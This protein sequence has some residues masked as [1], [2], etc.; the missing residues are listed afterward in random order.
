MAYLIDNLAEALNN[1]ITSARQLIEDCFTAIDAPEGEGSRAFITSYHDRARHHA[2]MI[3]HARKQGWPLPKYAGIPI[4]IKDLFNEAG[5]VTKA[6]SVVLQDVSP[7]DQDATVVA[8]LKA[9]GFIVIGRTNMTEFAF[10]GLGMNVHY[11]SPRSPFERDT[12]NVNSGRVSGG[13]SSGSAVSISDGM[14]AATI[15]SDTG[16]STRVPAAF[17]GIVG[18]KPS[19]SRMPNEGVYP[20]SKSFDVAGPMGASVRCCAILDSIMADKNF[21]TSSHFPLKN[22][23][24]GLPMGYLF[25]DLDDHVA[26]SFTLATN[27]LSMAGVKIQEIAIAQIEDLRPSNNNKSIVAAEA[28]ALHRERLESEAVKSYDPYIAHRLAGGHNISASVYIDMLA[29]RQKIWATV[30]AETDAFDALIL[31]TSPIIPPQLSTLNSIAAKTLANAQCLRNTSLSNYLDRPTV[32]LPCHETGTAP[33]G[34]SLI[35]PQNHDNRLLAIAASVESCLG[36]RH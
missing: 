22:L 23:R 24:L 7:A 13:S 12:K 9:A 5:Q 6:G 18:F 30:Q 10:S 19:T 32:T 29:A 14:A 4:S 3:D 33:V 1:N 35:G 17:C 11:G 16:G 36:A 25:D 20:L 15:G 34:L 27:L 8:R 31:P 2:D 28:Y 21:G 26:Q